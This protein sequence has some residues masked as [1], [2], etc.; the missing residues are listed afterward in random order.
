MAFIDHTR[1]LFKNGEYVPDEGLI[2]D[3]ENGDVTNPHPFEWS[4]DGLIHTVKNPFG[5]RVGIYDDITWYRS[6]FDRIYKR[7]GLDW[8]WREILRCKFFT[9][10][11][12]RIKWDLRL[13][14]AYDYTA[15][16]G[17]WKRGKDE[18]YIWHDCTRKSYA[19]FY[20]DGQDTYILLG[21][22]GHRGNVYTHF[23]G[24]GYGDEFEEKMA[25]EAYLWLCSNVLREITNALEYR[26]PDADKLYSELTQKFYI[27]E[28]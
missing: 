19:S 15:E 3:F 7:A 21:G 18:L 13:T 1:I 17:V 28:E 14:K 5:D 9:R 11:W 2:V 12:N 27:K 24:R 23:M 10:L 26:V 25:S 4:R 8:G 16:T 20:T 6:E 22:Y